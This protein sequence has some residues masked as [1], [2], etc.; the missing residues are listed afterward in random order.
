MDSIK[1]DHGNRWW[2]GKEEEEREREAI[3]KYNGY[4]K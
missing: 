3:F 1:V 4:F 2:V